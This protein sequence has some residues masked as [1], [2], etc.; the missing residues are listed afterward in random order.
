MPFCVLNSVTMPQHMEHFSRPLEMM[1]CLKDKPFAGT[2]CFLKAEL[3]L[4]VS[5]KADD[6]QQHGQVTKQYGKRTCSI[7][8]KIS[9]QNDCWWSEHEPGNRSF[10]TDCRIGDEKFVSRWCPGISQSNSGMRGW[11]QFLTSICLMV[12]LQPHYSPDLAPCD[13]FLLQK[14]KSAVKWNHFES[15]DNIQRSVTQVLK[16]PPTKYVPG[17]PQTMAAPLEKVCAGIR[18]VVCTL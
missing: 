10:D 13:F 12:M 18:D 3:L 16:R 4:K 14:W 2:T 7:L 1:Q 5:R 9:S 11:A 17:M 8:L 6:H 15:T